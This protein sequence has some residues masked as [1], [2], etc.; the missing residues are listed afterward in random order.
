MSCHNGFHS[1]ANSK[2]T[3]RFRKT[4]I[5]VECFRRSP[6]NSH[7]ALDGFR[8]ADHPESISLPTSRLA[9]GRPVVEKRPEKTITFDARSAPR[10]CA[11]TVQASV[12]PHRACLLQLVA[13]SRRDLWPLP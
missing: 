4:D 2:S 10:A 8:V 13:G 3:G 7:E 11:L 12:Q 1:Y 5:T 6:R 9:A